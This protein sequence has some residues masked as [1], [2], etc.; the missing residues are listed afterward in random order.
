MDQLKLVGG[1]DS[2]KKKKK[3]SCFVT[4][5]VRGDKQSLGNNVSASSFMSLSCCEGE[6]RGEMHDPLLSVHIVTNA[7]K[8][9]IKKKEKNPSV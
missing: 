1:F 6:V 9:K 2:K 7:K 8:I 3:R 4:R 5:C